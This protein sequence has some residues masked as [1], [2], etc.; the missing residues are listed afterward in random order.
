MNA[1][2]ITTLDP[3]SKNSSPLVGGVLQRKC[4]CGRHT[5]G[6]GSCAKCAGEAKPLGLQTKLRIGEP[7]D[8]FEQEADRVADR[9][10]GM[11][12]PSGSAPAGRGN[13]SQGNALVQRRA[14]FDGGGM[15]Q[16]PSI[17][18]DV[19]R[20]PGR[21]LDPA[22]RNYMEPRFGQDFSQVRVHT[23][24]RAAES[25]DSVGASAYTVG[26][27]IVF[28]GGHYSP[29]TNGGQKLLAHELAHTVQQ[30]GQIGTSQNVLQR[31][32]TAGGFFRNIFRGIASLFGDEPD[33]GDD[34]LLRY[35]E[36]LNRNLEIEDDFDSDNKARAVVGR[37]SAG[38]S[39]FKLTTRVKGLLIEEMLSGFTGGADEDAILLLLEGSDEF[40]M[41]AILNSVGKENLA[42]NIQGKQGESFERIV[43][44]SEKRFS[45]E[46]YDDEI[47][48]NYLRLLDKSDEIENDLDSRFKA[49]VAVE[50]WSKGNQAYIL[51]LDLKTLMIKEMISGFTEAADANAVL[52]ILKGSN[53]IEIGTILD[54]VGK[55]N[56]QGKLQGEQG[57]SFEKIVDASEKRVAQGNAITGDV[58]GGF[59]NVGDT[60]IDRRLAEYLRHIDVHDDVQQE[61]DSRRNAREV[62]QRW[63]SGDQRY[64][65]PPRR[66]QILINELLHGA[67]TL[68]DREAI[69]D[70][71]R[72]ANDVEM[73][74]ISQDP[75]TTLIGLRLEEP[76][77]SEFEQIL[78]AWEKGETQAQDALSKADSK[79]ID[80]IVVDQET[81]QTV[82]VHWKGG[83]TFSDICSTGKGHCCVGANDAQG[84]A[85]SEKESKQ[86][87]S[88]CTPVG[89]HTVYAK[90]P[91]TAAGVEFW[92]EFNSRS[93][94]LHDYDPLV[95]GTPLSHGCV[96]L[97]TPTAKMIYKG[98]VKN[99]TKVE[100][101]GLARP[102]CNWP[103]L[104][105]EW[106][107]DLRKAGSEV[108]D[109]E[110]PKVQARQQR[111]INRQRA[112]EREIFNISDEELKEKIK[113]L[114]KETGGLRSS[115]SVWGRRASR[116]KA[117]KKIQPVADI[118]PRCVATQT[119]EERNLS[120]R[121]EPA[122][123]LSASKLAGFA[124]SFRKDLVSARNF[125]R[126]EKVTARHGNLLWNEAVSSAQGPNADL[127]DRPLYWARLQMAQVIRE[128]TPAWHRTFSKTKTGTIDDIR[129][130]K[131][132][133]LTLFES[134]SRGMDTATFSATQ[135][136]KR[137][138]ISGFDPFGLHNHVDR[139]NPSGAAVLALD[140]RS[141]SA[142]DVNAQIQGVIFP[143][144]FSD[145]DAGRVENFFGPYILGPNPPDM[146]MT[147][148]MGGSED[149]EVEKF[150]GRGRSSGS[151]KGNLGQTSGGTLGSP[152]EAPGLSAGPEF[153]E[154]TLPA[155][156]IR[157]SQGRSK[158][159]PAETE[160]IEK[161]KGENRPTHGTGAPSQGSQAVK[162]SGGG[163]LSNEI[164]Y[165][166]SLLRHSSNVE[167]PI[168]HLHTPLLG[169]PRGSVDFKATRDQIVKEVEKI[170]KTTL[171]HI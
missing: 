58:G 155:D 153:L 24:S 2:R 109:G 64:Y 78:A 27:S 72:G 48:Q 128:F 168:G 151:F 59:A 131:T 104:Q 144:R 73:R 5:P 30:T 160:F 56:L 10:V 22:T 157:S 60:G 77:K 23:G 3:S 125:A 136:G 171:P 46:R 49:R 143:V 67:F 127:D 159:L 50:R 96:R 75:G 18:H 43:G 52:Q 28:G 124:K 62:I 123:I 15:T 41:K 147:I 156:A 29:G 134:A 89:E 164:F 76:Q 95:D 108:D 111:S 66:K 4:A 39:D 54:K 70:L 40:E 116:V 26:R 86:N 130:D 162:G 103:A 129:R 57:K 31:A 91:K 118:I 163:F 9:V 13:L 117:L 17:V 115:G 135:N 158:A 92:T 112:T 85:C 80:H 140:N 161:R 7:G 1:T 133:L 170:L 99:R 36:F 106:S 98:A 11:A 65:L 132:K 152:I 137:I 55:R 61:S 139:S 141:V 138:L 38:N 90:Y 82:T 87:G 34:V 101:K 88:N 113:E 84:A 81:P 35:L 148:S 14:N 110:P 25:A 47:L 102:R 122:S 42:S 16:A 68:E 83:G 167:I 165:R 45:Q 166:T 120:T 53:D 107:G 69:I 21:P 32:P 79:K 12:N 33:Y 97:R 74:L 20:S 150:A 51:T 146:I 8:R 6:G 142:G 149:F 100:V 145:F 63:K 71:L 19:L 154:T 105:A 44:A 114:E 121:Q 126:A 169:P 94:A 119:V 37:W 93:I